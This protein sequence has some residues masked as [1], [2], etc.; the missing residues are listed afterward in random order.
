M[1]ERI[2]G[3]LQALGPWGYLLLGLAALIEY[4]F[5]PFPGDSVLLLGGVYASRGE[6]SWVLVGLAVT[7]GSAVGL[8]AN[9]ALGRWVTKKFGGQPFEFR[10]GLNSTNLHWVQ[11]QLKKN[12]SW[13]L[14]VN[15]FLPTFRSL[16][17]IGAGAAELP[18][19]RVLVL[20]LV[21]ATA[22][23]AALLG[24]GYLL[25]GN[26]ELVEQFL[27]QYQRVAFIVIAAVVLFFAGRAFLKKK[28]EPSARD[29]GKRDTT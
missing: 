13:L 19:R 22:W 4:V 12:G 16:V 25:G 20:G 21:S 9:Y 1:V 5:P 27:K 11:A 28:R 6:R 8:S 26:A 29:P 14:V 10:F 2:D 3:W 7:L 23:N 15:R 17:F 24:L 18:F